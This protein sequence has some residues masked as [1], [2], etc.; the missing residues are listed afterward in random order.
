MKKHSGPVEFVRSHITNVRISIKTII[1]FV[2]VI[3]SF[4]TLFIVAVNSYNSVIG[5]ILKNTENINKSELYQMNQILE[6]NIL[7]IQNITSSISENTEITNLIGSFKE[8]TKTWDMIQAG[9]DIENILLTYRLYNEN[10]DTIVIFTNH[11]VFSSGDITFY[12]I[13]QKDIKEDEK[14]NSVLMN[15]KKPYFFETDREV[16]VKSVLPN[17]YNKINVLYKKYAF[18]KYI[19]KD[20]GELGSVFVILKDK[21][22]ENLMNGKQNFAILDKKDQIV[23]NKSDYEDHVL[24]ELQVD[25]HNGKAIQTKFIGWEII[26]FGNI[27][28]VEKKLGKVKNIIILFVVAIIILMIPIS[29]IL[30]NRIYKA[31]SELT[32]SAK[33]YKAEDK[34]AETAVKF[35]GRSKITL[36]EKILYYFLTVIFIPILLYI[37]LFY[38]ISADIV[39]D[40][41]EGSININFKH[42]DNSIEKFISNEEKTLRNIIFD[43]KLQKY[44][45]YREPTAFQN[46]DIQRIIDDKMRMG[47][48]FYQFDIYGKENN[49]LFSNINDGRNKKID[50]SI[51]REIDHTIGEVLWS[52]PVNDDFGRWLMNAYVK[53]KDISGKSLSTIGYV[54]MGLEEVYLE[55][56]YKN[57]LDE[58][59]NIIIVNQK[60]NIVSSTNKESIGTE[61]KIK[62]REGVSIIRESGNKFL[63]LKQVLKG[64][65]WYLVS[66]YNYQKIRIG[67]RQILYYNFI[68][69]LV[70]FL[71]III[72]SYYFSFLFIKPLN[73]FN[74][75]LGNFKLGNLTTIYPE[76][77]N[78]SE[79]E[80]LGKSF[81]DMVVRIENLIDDVLIARIEKTE[82][83]QEKK[84]LEL[85]VLQA[86]INPH[87]LCNTLENIK[88][89]LDAPDKERPI[90]MINALNNLFKYGISRTESLITISQEIMYTKAYIE[91]VQI[92][93]NKRIEFIWD[94]D[95]SILNYKVPKLILQPL[96]ENVI[97]HGFGNRKDDSVSV[98]IICLNGNK[99]IQFFIKDNGLG[100]DQE[101]LNEIRENIANNMRD[102]SIGLSNVNRRI[103]LFF[104][105]QYGISISSIPL[106]H[107]E[108]SFNIPKIS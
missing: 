7:E 17:V 20:S 65:Q 25:D 56:L 15:S 82:L 102:K 3:L 31:L 22:V 66:V 46:N 47:Q 28:E 62:A 74:I 64:T 36:R 16:T 78:I 55:Q 68:I 21:W 49:L 89:M 53:I 54:K 19:I 37:G 8:D 69:L 98:H 45:Y 85:V 40:E 81:N 2:S 84:Q 86:Q 14:I 100:M 18:G 29:R 60:N 107:T 83:E 12:N 52:E 13:R 90:K 23:V 30:L 57:S 32:K 1:L 75:L 76:D 70:L 108:V 88:W 9:K 10:I 101:K 92:R 38:F 42:I 67:T 61:L 97:N 51:Y 24:G 106:V 4:M 94:I 103:K 93:F 33:Q 11:S 50:Q 96:I 77:N 95:D 71:V 35:R 72:L 48:H 87:F 80:E 91:I 34:F 26:Y 59:T 104:G 39:N 5:F 105:E 44:L 6:S 73:K 58:Y 79:I 63:V 43:D 27:G 99:E 41:I